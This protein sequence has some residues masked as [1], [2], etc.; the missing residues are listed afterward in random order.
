[1]PNAMYRA[2]EDLAREIKA[3]LEKDGYYVMKSGGSRGIV[4]LIALKP[5]ETLLIQAKKQGRIS[6]ADR[7]RLTETAR[8]R[9]PPCLC[10]KVTPLVAAWT[11][12]GRDARRPGYAELTGAR[13]DQ[14]R[15]WSPDHALE[16]G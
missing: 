8:D 16:T 7:A 2:G 13:I 15:P 6:P 9:R 10:C 11:K 12:N 1:M 14:Q 4:D 3:R 5:G